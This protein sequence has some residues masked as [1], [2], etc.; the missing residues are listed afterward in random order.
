MPAKYHTVVV[1]QI[2]SDGSVD[3]SFRHYPS[4]Y[5]LDAALRRI[6]S[7]FNMDH[8]RVLVDGRVESAPAPKG[9]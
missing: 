1:E 5:Q 7:A 4:T 6:R 3:R 9:N 8:T 2:G